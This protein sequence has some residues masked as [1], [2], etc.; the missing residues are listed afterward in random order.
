MASS[1]KIKSETKTKL[2]KLQ[3]TIMLKFGKKLS[4][5][6]LI[7]LLVNL[8]EKNPANL[9]ERKRLT[10]EKVKEILALSEAWPIE[11]DPEMLDDLLLED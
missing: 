4:Q 2:D 5:Q 10:K 7:E 8:G 6:D 3:A 9:F 1:I 11:T